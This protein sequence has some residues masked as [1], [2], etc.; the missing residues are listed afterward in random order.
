MIRL[1]SLFIALFFLLIFLFVFKTLSSPLSSQ[2]INK[3]EFVISPGQSLDTIV[4]NLKKQ[5]LIKSSTTAK[6]LIFLKGY[7]KKI[8]A[9]YFYLSPSDN[10]SKIVEKL[11]HASTKQIWVTI[12]E[13]LRREEIAQIIQAALVKQN[14]DSQNDPKNQFNSQDFITLTQTLEGHLFP[15]TYAFKPD[16]TTQEAVDKLTTLFDQTIKDLK[17]NPQKLNQIVILASLLERESQKVEE[18]P[19][20]AGILLKRVEND[21]PLQVDAT[22]QY[23]KANQVCRQLSCD[24]WPTPLSKA[25]LQINSPFNTYIN[26][27]LPL[28]PISNPGKKALES[29]QNPASSQYWFYLHDLKGQVYYAQTVEKH[30]QN[31]CQ[32]LN[33]DC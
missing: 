30:N 3:Q 12:P 28:K 31:I 1:R 9:G 13:G 7:S 17:I 27:G 19:L 14:R 4:K 16:I 15:E 6:A 20:I 18:M 32:F 21:W 33:K 8:Q 26:Q 11:T 24:W 22:V 29:A 10:L 25:D 5:N 23:A 2:N